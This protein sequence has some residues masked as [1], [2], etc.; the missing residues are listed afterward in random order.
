MRI[1]THDKAGSYPPSGRA[2]IDL[3]ADGT[4]FN[5]ECPPDCVQLGRGSGA[6]RSGMQPVGTAPSGI[7]VQKEFGWIRTFVG[8]SP[9]ARSGE[10]T[11]DKEL[12]PEI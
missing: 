12:Q 9:P 4:F 1:G 3:R 11:K 6:C 7:L 10:S 2:S 5:I 8:P